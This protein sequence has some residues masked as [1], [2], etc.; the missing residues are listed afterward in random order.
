MTIPV[1]EERNRIAHSRW[2]TT[3]ICE[4]MDASAILR[5]KQSKDQRKGW[6]MQGEAWKLDRFQM[7]LN[8]IQNA[9]AELS[10]F[11]TFAHELKGLFPGC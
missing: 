3:A 9:R 8:N 1:L 6:Q 11:A 7:I 5:I 10:A 4:T 2:C